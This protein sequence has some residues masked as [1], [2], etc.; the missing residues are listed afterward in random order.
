MYLCVR[1]HVFVCQR[2]CICVLDVMYL[3]VRGHVFV[4]QGSCICVL[5]VMYLCV[6]GHV[7]VCQGYGFCLFLRFFYRIFFSVVFFCF[8]YFIIDNTQNYQ[9]ECSLCLK[10]FF[11]RWFLPCFLRIIYNSN[12]Y[13][14]Q[15]TFICVLGVTIC[16]FLR[17]FYW[18]L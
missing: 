17:F 8:F 2:S 16:L 11:F 7:F 18:I 1:G 15:R 4:C 12:I 14:V 13:R 6:R 5:D 9:L 3:C 10:T